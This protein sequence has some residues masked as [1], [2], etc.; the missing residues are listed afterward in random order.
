MLSKEISQCIE[1]MQSAAAAGMITLQMQVRAYDLLDRLLAMDQ[2]DREAW[3]PDGSW[4]P[5]SSYVKVRFKTNER[6]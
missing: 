6:I 4:R 2:T 5:E 3:L 1:D